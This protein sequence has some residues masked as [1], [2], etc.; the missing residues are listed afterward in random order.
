MLGFGDN[1]L[2]LLASNPLYLRELIETYPTAKIVLLHS[3]YPYTRQAGYLASVYSNVYVD[4]GLVF[5]LIS[6]TGQ[7]ANLKELVNINIITLKLLPLILNK[8]IIIIIQFEICPN[9]KIL[10]S[11]G[12]KILIYS[13]DDNR[14]IEHF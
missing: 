9:N 12:K 14:S 4:F 2:D 10:F 8:F 5:P 1:D 13:M 3:A 6:A 7:Q 11:T